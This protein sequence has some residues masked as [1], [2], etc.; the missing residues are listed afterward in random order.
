MT[1]TGTELTTEPSVPVA[2]TPSGS[3]RSRHR[4][5][6]ARQLRLGA[7]V[8]SFALLTALVLVA[9]LV[10]LPYSA[11]EPGSARP[12]SDLIT[13]DGAPPP[14][15]PTGLL[16]FTTVTQREATLLDVLRGWIDDDVEL[17]ASDVLRGGQS[18]EENARY[19]AQLMDVSKVAAQTAALR[20]IG[21]D[22]PITTSG[23]VVRRI[24]PGTP[25]ESVLQLDDVVVAVDGEPVDRLEE[26][27][28]LLQVGGVGAGHALT[29]E[30]P[31]GSDTRVEVT[32]STMAAE[33]DASRAIIGIVPEERISDIQLPIHVDI[34]SGRVA[35]PSA[36]LAFALAIIDALTP[37][38]L[39]GGHKIAVTGTIDLLGNV[40]PV[41][42]GVQKA[43]AVR[44][45]GYEAFLVPPLEL[46]E[47]RAAVG[48]D[49]TVIAVGTL[50]EALDALASLGGDL[51]GLDSA[52]ASTAP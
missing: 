48:G 13:V 49:L 11:I 6:T 16:A 29:V 35:G 25:A 28:D 32:V 18:R 20:R 36:G 33:G 22:V 14:Y 27:G 10:P 7:A 1:T 38:E 37:G 39:T 17:V 40:G 2:P 23:T 26:L 31:A 19:N 5:P 9:V 46:E 4:G 8:G 47:V 12:V 42:G 41:G 30:R 3:G 21:Y 52:G 43:V 51:S 15:P 34:R 24:F 50:D 44:N 45:A